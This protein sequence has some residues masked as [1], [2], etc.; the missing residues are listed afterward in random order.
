[1]ASLNFVEKL[2]VLFYMRKWYRKNLWHCRRFI[3][4]PI[5]SLR[6]LIISFKIKLF[7]LQWSTWNLLM[8]LVTTPFQFQL[9]YQLCAHVCTN[10]VKGSRFCLYFLGIEMTARACLC[11]TRRALVIEEALQ[12][13][14]KRTCFFF[15]FLLAI[16]LKITN[17]ES[18]NRLNLALEKALEAKFSN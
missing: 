2:L 1:M 12:N 18:T 8:G 11:K 17:Y 14:S 15:H 3:N 6:L 13:S 16:S 4:S 5:R 9:Y 7:R 10:Y